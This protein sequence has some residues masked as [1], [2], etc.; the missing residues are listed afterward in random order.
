MCVKL[1]YDGKYDWMVG[2]DARSWTVL[3]HYIA[4]DGRDL[5]K[6]TW[7]GAANLLTILGVTH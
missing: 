3:N 5:F 2:E 6:T 4:A 1:R 7:T